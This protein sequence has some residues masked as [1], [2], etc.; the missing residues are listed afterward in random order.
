MDFQVVL[1]IFKALKIQVS[2]EV[3]DFRQGLEILGAVEEVLDVVIILYVVEVAEE[4]LV[5][6]LEILVAVQEI[7]EVAREILE[8]AQEISEVAQ[9]MGEIL[10]VESKVRYMRYTG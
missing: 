8:M 1:V 3:V 7:L 9:D 4:T 6:V 5:V 10:E 2:M